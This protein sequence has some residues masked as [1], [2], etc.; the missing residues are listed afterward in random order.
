MM[1]RPPFSVSVGLLAASVTLGW[2]RPFATPNTN[3]GLPDLAANEE[4]PGIEQTGAI[5][6]NGLG[7]AQLPPMACLCTV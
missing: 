4:D 6:R 5:I 7:L 1:S 2:F 3:G